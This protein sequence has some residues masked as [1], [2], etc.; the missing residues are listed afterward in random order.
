MI[1]IGMVCVTIF[2]IFLIVSEFMVKSRSDIDSHIFCPFSEKGR[3]SNVQTWFHSNN[4]IS[5][6]NKNDISAS[7]IDANKVHCT[8]K[9]NFNDEEVNCPSDFHSNGSI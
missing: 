1:V 6:Y 5:K 9:G 7:N 2:C 3:L 4:N 8:T